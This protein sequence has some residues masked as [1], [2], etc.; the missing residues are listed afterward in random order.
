MRRKK[1]HIMDAWDGYDPPMNDRDVIVAVVLLTL[2]V[3]GVACILW[4]MFAEATRFAR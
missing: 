1:G 3:G 4:T 2:V